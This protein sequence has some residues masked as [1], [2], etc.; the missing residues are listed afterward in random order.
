MKQDEKYYQR[1]INSACFYQTRALHFIDLH[2]R[3]ESRWEHEGDLVVDRDESEKKLSILNS[4]R[5][6]NETQMILSESKMLQGKAR[7]D[8]VYEALTSG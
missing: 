7:M 5:L 2:D 1:E 6:T 3:H 4:E 8:K